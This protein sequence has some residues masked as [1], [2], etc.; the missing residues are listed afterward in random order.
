MTRLT[1]AELAIK[2][3]ITG[4]AH[5]HDFLSVYC[6]PYHSRSLARTKTNAGGSQ[7]SLFEIT[8]D[9][10]T[11]PLLSVVTHHWANTNLKVSS[12]TAYKKVAEDGWVTV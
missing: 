8:R 1:T 5:G 7:H 2:A 6:T 9:L 12:E 11:L 4:N 10:E 3:R